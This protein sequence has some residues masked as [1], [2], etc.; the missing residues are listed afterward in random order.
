[1][2]QTLSRGMV[3][4]AAATSILSLCGSSALADADA[5]GAAKGSP[6]VVSGNSVQVPL[7]VPLN[8]C[9]N[10]VDVIGAL[11]PAFGNSCANE[12]GPH[13]SGSPGVT[14][15]PSPS[16]DDS[17][18][19][20]GYGY[21]D[22]YG[23]E[24]PGSPSYG[25]GE[26]TP[27]YGETPDGYGETP[28]GYGETPDGYGETPG[29]YGE[30]PPTKPPT[31]PPHTTPPPTS[32]PTKPP[33]TPPTSPPHSPP[34]SPPHTM[35]PHTMPPPGGEHGTPPQL[36]ETGSEA[37]LAASGVSFALIAGGAVL[38]RR[39]RAASRR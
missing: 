21:G 39:G 2:R 15:G 13:E 28:D 12:S 18:P 8:D 11:N 14:Q 27:G 36:P 7:E 29:G 24:T 32:P 20:P 38:Y 33:H 4:A 17:G 30:T 25:D 37:M 6:G 3:T 10:S 5:S 35:P 34:T 9:G 26:E 31:S 19:D 23:E 22:G 16:D 1:M